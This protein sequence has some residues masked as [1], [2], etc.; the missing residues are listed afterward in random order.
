MARA[1][2]VWG[3]DV[4]QVALK[5]LKLR[6][7]DGQI[8]V[9][10][11]QTIE[12]PTILSQPDTDRPALIHEALER[13]LAAESVSGCHVVVSV[14]GQSGYTKFTK[15]PP[16]EA[17]RVPDIVRFEAEQQIPFPIGEVV[18]RWQ[19]FRDPDSPDVEVGLFAMKRA[20]VAE[21]LSYFQGADLPVDTIQMAPLALY[22][23]LK[24]DEQAAEDGATLLADVGADKTDLVVSD[25]VR[26]WTRTIQIGGNN[27]TEALVRTFK[28]SFE[29]A[30]K[31][32]RSAASSKYARQ[33]FQAM[34]PV[35]ADLVQ[36]IQRSLGYYTSLHRE[37]R[38]KRLVGLGNG[39]RLPGLQKFIEQNLNVPVVRIDA[40]NKL[41]PSALVNAPALN[42]NVLSFAV[43]YGLAVQGL[44]KAAVGTNLLPEEILR[45]RR[46]AQKRPWFAG[47]AAVLLAALFCPGYR[48]GQDSQTLSNVSVLSAA[49]STY[50][51]LK[52][53]IDKFQEIK[54][55]GGKEEEEIRKLVEL[56]G[57]RDFWPATKGLIDRSVASVAT[58]QR[59]LTV[60][61]TYLG[62]GEPAR[63]AVA[64]GKDE[65]GSAVDRDSVGRAALAVL[66]DEE[67]TGLDQLV[68]AGRPGDLKAR[69][70]AMAKDVGA[71]PNAV[72]ALSGAAL[73]EE[74]RR[75][76]VAQR[77]RRL[78][79][80]GKIENR[81]ARQVIVMEAFQPKHVPELSALGGTQPEAKG[82]GFQLELIGRTPLPQ[83]QANKMLATLRRHSAAL[84]R[85]Y[86]SVA[87]V[88]HRI[89]WMPMSPD[90]G[91]TLGAGPAAGGG[92]KM[93]D[94]LMPLEDMST[95]A[96]F[97]I[98]W[99]VTITSDGLVLPDV[100]PGRTYRTTGPV[101]L[102][103]SF[104]PADALAEEKQIKELPAG[105][106][107]SVQGVQKRWTIE[108]YRV[109]ATD[110]GGQSLGTGW[111][112]GAALSPNKIEPVE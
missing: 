75:L 72:G 18:W 67:R 68:T 91:F 81:R 43:A 78:E 23:F 82:P 86:G 45:K 93:P 39:F 74:V 19:T 32:K 107:L 103:P 80:F 97:K 30:E 10:A 44:D 41:A 40:Y 59:L 77:I 102:L 99:L 110:A 88:D 35:F 90:A 96:R 106:S 2:A 69:A 27:F 26:V 21:V 105:T 16:V 15:L 33:V 1:K 94:P 70:L 14:S 49:D 50:K 58:D 38:F 12:H 13:F 112:S 98:T 79:A 8:Q 47:A 3:I 65:S 11:F 29:K 52:Q 34:R 31:L 101:D 42:E 9:E 4:G 17:K 24:F 51:A 95:D 111:V 28:L 87:V 64:T 109:Q 46:W 37:T 73:G 20:D 56:F 108:W 89:E 92:P 48:A 55:K 57:Y 7:V 66:T 61:G 85:W 76:T 60:Y 54:D 63:R 62:L 25:G 104:A 53:R 36:E 100:K 84:A 71:D 83:D 5:A 6:E 22:N